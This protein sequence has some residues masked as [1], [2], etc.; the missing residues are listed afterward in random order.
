MEEHK[1]HVTQ[2]KIDIK[3]TDFT[4]V[5]AFHEAITEL[6]E[7]SEFDIEIMDDA[8]SP[9]TEDMTEQYESFGAINTETIESKVANK[10]W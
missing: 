2:L 7:N 9:Y 6:N 4:Q 8:N 5:I 3:Y 1:E 10:N